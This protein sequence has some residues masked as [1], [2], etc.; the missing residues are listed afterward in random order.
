MVKAKE[1]LIPTA[2]LAFAVAAGTMAV[3]TQNRENEAREQLCQEDPAQCPPPNQH[4]DDI[5]IIPMPGGGVAF[6]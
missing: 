1:I 2:L 5:M 6:F 4:N 3:I